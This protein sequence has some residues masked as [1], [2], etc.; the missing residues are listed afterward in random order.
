MACHLGVFSLCSPQ[1][2]RDMFV[3]GS[4]H[5]LVCVCV[6][7]T[8]ADACDLCWSSSCWRAPA[9]VCV[10]TRMCICRMRV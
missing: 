5:A 7:V 8:L 10:R 6:H 9:H 1:Q 4:S 2:S 3:L